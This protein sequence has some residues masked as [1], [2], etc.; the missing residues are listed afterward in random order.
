MNTV[1]DPTTKSEN[2]KI[3]VI[4]ITGKL[5]KAVLVKK[6]QEYIDLIINHLLMLMLSDDS[7]N[8]RAEAILNIELNEKTIPYIVDRSLDRS[9]KVRTAAY[10]SLKERSTLTFQQINILDRLQIIINGLNDC[11]PEVKDYCREYII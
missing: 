8:V 1:N 9:I 4:R 5:F 2:I 3:N 11:E 10:K 7:E 6:K